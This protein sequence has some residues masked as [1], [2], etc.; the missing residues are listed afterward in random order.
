MGGGSQEMMGSPDRGNQRRIDADEVLQQA[1]AISQED[2]ASVLDQ[3]DEEDQA[4]EEEEK[5]ASQRQASQLWPSSSAQQHQEDAPEHPVT[6]TELEFD[7]SIFPPP[8]RQRSRTR[9]TSPTKKP[10]GPSEV[11][12]Q[13]EGEGEY[14]D[15]VEF[16]S[17]QSGGRRPFSTFF[18]D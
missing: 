16:E 12:E 10:R 7:E 18:E 15:E 5:A 4:E 17:T 3:M 8:A 2:L 9:S 14:D 11:A 1:M 6:L 13:E